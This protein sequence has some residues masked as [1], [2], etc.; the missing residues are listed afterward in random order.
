M[1][2]VVPL[3]LRRPV[4]VFLCACALACIFSTPELVVA[5]VSG[6]AAANPSH[7]WEWLDDKIGQG[8]RRL[9]RADLVTRQPEPQ[10]EDFCLL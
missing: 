9:S 7:R 4:R 2:G 8:D 1:T 5:V 10:A 6:V 3:L